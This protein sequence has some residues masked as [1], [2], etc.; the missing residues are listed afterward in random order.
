[1]PFIARRIIS[2]REEKEKVIGISW[3]VDGCL[4]SPTYMLKHVCLYPKKSG[5][6]P[7]C[8]D[9]LFKKGSLKSSYTSSLPILLPLK[10]IISHE[11][12]EVNE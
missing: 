11:D 7:L 1:M 10:E 6:K 12:E 4:L 8:I 3:E 9:I 5:S 2:L